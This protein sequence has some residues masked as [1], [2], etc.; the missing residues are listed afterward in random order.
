M[1]PTAHQQMQYFQDLTLE[2]LDADDLAELLSL[3]KKFEKLY[4]DGVININDK[5]SLLS[6]VSDRRWSLTSS[7]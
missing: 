3:E 2:I 4:T 1:S 6:V 7:L 5:R